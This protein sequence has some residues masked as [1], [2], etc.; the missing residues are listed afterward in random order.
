VRK[1]IIIIALLATAM[2]VQA[3]LGETR[4]QILRRFGGMEA[5]T[6]N[7]SNVMM[8]QHKNLAQIYFDANGRSVVEMYYLSTRYTKADPYEIMR[9]VL[10]SRPRFTTTQV[11]PSCWQSTNS[12]YEVGFLIDPP[13]GYKWG[14]AVGYTSAMEQF[15]AWRDDKPKRSTVLQPSSPPEPEQPSRY[16]YSDPSRTPNDCSIIASKAYHELKDVTSWCQV[17]SADLILSIGQGKH[18]V[19]AFKYQPDG[20]VFIYDELGSL[21]LDTE[22]EDTEAIKLAWQVKLNDLKVLM[23]VSDL[24]FVTH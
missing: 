12:V 13:P 22:L 24:K 6:A 8:F 4:E 23:I 1:L 2:T 21:E 7:Y 9:T 11:H 14:F 16:Y 15:A 19:V 3:K 17:I 5:V 10:D 20:H 18:A